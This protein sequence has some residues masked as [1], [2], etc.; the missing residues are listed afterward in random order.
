MNNAKGVLRTVSRVLWFIFILALLIVLVQVLYAYTRGEVPSV[1]GYSVL[2][3]VSGSM[4]DTIPT[5]SYILVKKTAPDDI[6]KGDIIC[7]YSTDPSIFGYPNTHRVD[8]EPIKTDSGYEYVTRGDAN[9]KADEYTASS[10][11]LIGKHVATLTV[12]G[13]IADALTQSYSL[14]FIIGI[15]LA[16]CAMIGYSLVK[17]AADKDGSEG[18]K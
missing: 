3:V 2:R 10:E 6:K 14:L 16:L 17:R 8:S 1:F 5:G 13:K 4:E 9:P 11:R 18:K 12:L 7:F 15:Q